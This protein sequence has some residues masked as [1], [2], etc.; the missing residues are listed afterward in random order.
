MTTSRRSRA[1]RQPPL[2]TSPGETPRHGPSRRPG[3]HVHRRLTLCRVLRPERSGLR[4][5]APRPDP[6]RWWPDAGGKALETLVDEV[7]E[8]TA[9]VDMHVEGR[10]VDGRAGL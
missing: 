8:V 4:R 9:G 3:D 10:Q 7:D 1:G 5:A 2:W 6:F